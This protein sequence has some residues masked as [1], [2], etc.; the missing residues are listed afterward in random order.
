MEK[1]MNALWGS[2]EIYNYPV[3][4]SPHYLLKL[5]LHN[6]HILKSVLHSISFVNRRMSLCVR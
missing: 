6:Q 4:V 2:Y 3:T 1:G 5:E